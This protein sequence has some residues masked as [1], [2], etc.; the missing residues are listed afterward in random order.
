[1]GTLGYAN[2]FTGEAQINS[3]AP[4]FQRP[5]TISHEVAHQLG[6]GSESEA[7]LIG[8]LACRSSSDSLFRYSAY[9][10]LQLHTL[11]EMYRL[12]SARAI[13]LAKL[14]PHY[15]RADRDSARRF[16]QKYKNP[17]DP[18]IY[19]V[20]DWYLKINN[21]PLGQQSY[22]YVV[23]WLVGYARKNGWDAL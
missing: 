19:K 8:Y 10:S 1:M 12:D 2:P 14:T 4:A 13:Q 22:N 7:N 17:F 3:L 16:W 23:A 21:Q 5:F 15:L 6:Y 11:R 20:Y 18:L 9:S